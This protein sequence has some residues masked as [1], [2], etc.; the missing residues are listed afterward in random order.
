MA[1]GFMRRH[2][3]WLY[4]FLW[5]VIAAFIIL[6]IPAFQGVDA[7]SPGE[8]LA[9]V[10]SLPITV[11]EFQKSFQSQRRFY[12]RL[13]EGRLDPAAFRR[14]GLEEQTFDSLVTERLITL[15]ARRLGL[16]V[17]DEAVKRT[18]ETS[19][20]FQEGG[21]FLGGEEIRRRLEMQGVAVQE[22]EQSLRQKLLR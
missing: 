14:L 17:S 6:Y 11:G 20:E 12:E 3:R 10:G 5:L 8:V 15:E 18:L 19:P 7:G 22:F 16:S 1:L 13:Y 9:K 4:V 21:R 2:R